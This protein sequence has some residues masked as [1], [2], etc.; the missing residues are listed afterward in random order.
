MRPHEQILQAIVVTAELT[1]T[2]LSPAAQA[3]MVDDLMPYPLRAVLAAL[4]RCRKELTGRLTLAAV[5]ERLADY[6]G[7]PGAEEAWGMVAA[8]LT[9]E[10]ESIV[11]SDEM[12]E[13]S[14]PARELM[15][16][17]DKVGARMAFRE[18][19][20]RLVHEARDA[21]KSPR[22]TAS[23]GTDPERRA[24]VLMRAVELGRLQAAQV[25]AML[26]Y[27]ATEERH[28]L[29]T[30][31]VMTPEERRIGQQNVRKLLAMIPVK[32][33]EDDE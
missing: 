33:I 12:A 5:L 14:I 25:S 16:L 17:G 10:R 11:W 21:G 29:L 32:P 27:Q 23:A 18:S 2:E 31:Q 30:G 13:A 6:D 28:L 22:W 19:Y 20:E 1:G 24:A 9:D 26:P 15:S 3:V 8:A 7:R 4:T